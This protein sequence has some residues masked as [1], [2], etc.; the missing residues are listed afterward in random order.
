MVVFSPAIKFRQAPMLTHL[1]A[2][3]EES[4]RNKLVPLYSRAIY[5]A[6]EKFVELEVGDGV[7][8]KLV[9]FHYPDDNQSQ[10]N[11]SGNRWDSFTF[12]DLNKSYN[13]YR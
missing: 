1:Q 2:S 12:L 13:L 5:E 4:I 9:P 3:K 11:S 6:G 8:L 7:K 10:I